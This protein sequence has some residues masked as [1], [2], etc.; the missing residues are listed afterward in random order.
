M[1]KRELGKAEI[2]EGRERKK[3]RRR[4]EWVKKKGRSENEKKKREN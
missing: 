3:E 4:L 1:G 2:K